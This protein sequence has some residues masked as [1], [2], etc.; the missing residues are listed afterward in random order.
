MRVAGYPFWARALETV[1]SS[2]VLVTA[3]DVRACAREYKIRTTTDEGS[4]ELPK[5]LVNQNLWLVTSAK[6]T[7]RDATQPDKLLQQYVHTHSM[8]FVVVLGVLGSSQDLPKMETT[9]S[10][11]H[12]A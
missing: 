5:R 10:C 7:L 9:S 3:D 6:K 1:C 8:R 11:R 2:C 4:S 12:G